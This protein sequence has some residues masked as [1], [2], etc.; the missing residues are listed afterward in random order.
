MV[1]YR[2]YIQD[3]LPA[4]LHTLSDDSDDVVLLNLQVYIGVHILLIKLSY[5]FTRQRF[6]LSVT[7]G[8]NVSLRSQHSIVFLCS[9]RR[10]ACTTYQSCG[11]DRVRVCSCV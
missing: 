2:R 4:L 5:G 9:R 10:S 3:L 7:H 11:I 1:V 8:L 6:N